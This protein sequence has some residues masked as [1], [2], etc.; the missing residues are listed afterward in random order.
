MGLVMDQNQEKLNQ[1][2]QTIESD[3]SSTVS[4]S[5]IAVN[6]SS[7]TIN[8]ISDISTLQTTVPCIVENNLITL[9]H[10]TAVDFPNIS[11]NSSII[12]RDDHINNTINNTESSL[13]TTHDC[14]HAM[15]SVEPVYTLVNSLPIGD[16]QSKTINQIINLTSCTDSSDVMY[17]FTMAILTE[18]QTASDVNFDNNNNN[19]V[20]TVS[21]DHDPT[22]DG[23]N[24]NYDD[25]SNHG[26]AVVSKPFYLNYE[27]FEQNDDIFIEACSVTSTE[28]CIINCITDVVISAN[29]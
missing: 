3:Q 10:D 16:Q 22:H 8:E 4:F 27:P 18:Q 12:C 24:S 1:T 28:S 6:D 20:P 5:S 26:L 15:M 7:S 14:D 21:S 17:P 2:V 29:N 23:S 13:I 25:G 9:Y 19:Q 11:F